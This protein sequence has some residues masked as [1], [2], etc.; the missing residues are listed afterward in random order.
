MNKKLK[1][2]NKRLSARVSKMESERENVDRHTDC[3]C[4]QSLDLNKTVEHLRS[5]LKESVTTEYHDGLMSQ[6]S[7]TIAGLHKELEELLDKIDLMRKEATET[8]PLDSYNKMMKVINKQAEELQNTIDGLR[9]NLQSTD[10]YRYRIGQLK[11]Q[12]NILV[13]KVQFA[14][15]LF[16]KGK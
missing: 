7:R 16:L 5:K 9:E 1:E 15:K 14:E 4:E 11:E 13:G 3:N 2:S 10:Q 12:N 8:L 6:A